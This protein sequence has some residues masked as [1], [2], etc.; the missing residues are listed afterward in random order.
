MLGVGTFRSRRRARSAKSLL[1]A[2]PFVLVWLGY[3]QF[4]RSQQTK[5]AWNGTIVRQYQE[6]PFLG[7]GRSTPNRYWDVRMGDGEV[8]TVRVY[9]RSLWNDGIPGDWVIKRTGELDPVLISRR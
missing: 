2:I 3:D 1:I 5:E 4:Q 8:R 7:S 9:T 6:R